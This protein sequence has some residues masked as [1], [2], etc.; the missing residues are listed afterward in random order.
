MK[1]REGANICVTVMADKL[2]EV[3]SPISIIFIFLANGQSKQYIKALL[4][5]GKCNGIF[6]YIGR[7]IHYGSR[8]NVYGFSS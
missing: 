7:R 4:N 5:K 2:S 3:F 1:N 8:I 6:S